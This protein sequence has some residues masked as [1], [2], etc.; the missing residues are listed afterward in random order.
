MRLRCDGI[1]AVRKRAP[2]RKGARKVRARRPALPG[3]RALLRAIEYAHSPQGRLE[4]ALAGLAFRVVR[5]IVAP[6]RRGP[7]AL[8]G[9]TEADHCGCGAHCLAPKDERDRLDGVYRSCSCTG[10]MAPSGVEA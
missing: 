4:A 6:P 8:C 7:C 9:H 5:E 10:Y 2:R 1:E 3:L